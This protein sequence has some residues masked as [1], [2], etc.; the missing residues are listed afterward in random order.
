MKDNLVAQGY[1]PVW[2]Q[3]N[4]GHTCGNWRSHLDLALEYFFPVEPMGV[5]NIETDECSLICYPN[6]SNYKITIEISGFTNNISLNMV[7]LYGQQI[8]TF[9]ITSPVS[10]LDISTLPSGVY[11]LK[12]AGEK[13]IQV[14]RFVK[15]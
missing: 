8:M 12:A 3:W 4:E 1:N 5:E 2:H 14:G 13:G 15:Q 7:N 9:K 10:T 6:P 11:F